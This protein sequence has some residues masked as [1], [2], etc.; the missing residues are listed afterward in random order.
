MERT[1]IRADGQFGHLF[2]YLTLHD[3]NRIG[4]Y[5]APLIAAPSWLPSQYCLPA[6]V[7]LH[8]HYVTTFPNIQDGLTPSGVVNLKDYTIIRHTNAFPHII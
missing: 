8:Y 3:Y 5:S 2:H 1:A 4:R 6:F 7:D